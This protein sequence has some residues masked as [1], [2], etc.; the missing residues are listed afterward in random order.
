MKRDILRTAGLVAAGIAATAGAW[1]E[2]QQ[3]RDESGL[4]EVTV[5]AERKAEGQTLREVPMAVSAISGDIVDDARLQSVVGASV[6]YA[7][8]KD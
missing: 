5:Y 2:P 1:A 4:E 3:A 6:G 8:G 7:F